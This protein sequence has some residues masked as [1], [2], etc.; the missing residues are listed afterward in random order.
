[1]NPPIKFAVNTR[2]RNKEWDFRVLSG[3]F[4]DKTGTLDDV[5]SHIR[6]GHALCA[7]LLGGRRDIP[8]AQLG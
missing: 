5:M 8:D 3:K 7:G 6:Q 4:Q 1:M 2:G